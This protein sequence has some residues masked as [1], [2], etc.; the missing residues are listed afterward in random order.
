MP[1]GGFQFGGGVDRRS[2]PRMV[3]PAKAVEA[4]NCDF[5]SGALRPV[6][7]PTNGPEQLIP[8]GLIP[9]SLRR[10]PDSATWEVSGKRRTYSTVY[11]DPCWSTDDLSEPV[12]LRTASRKREAGV[13]PTTEDELRTLRPVINKSDILIYPTTEAPLLNPDYTWNN[14]EPQYL[15]NFIQVLNARWN[16]T[17]WEGSNLFVTV[18]RFRLG[19]YVTGG[20]RELAGKLAKGARLSLTVNGGITTYRVH[21]VEDI[22][23]YDAEDVVLAGGVGGAPI[24]GSRFTA[25]L[26]ADLVST[27]GDVVV[28]DGTNAIPSGVTEGRIYYDSGS[29]FDIGL[30][31]VVDRPKVFYGQVRV[32][33]EAG[34]FL[35]VQKVNE[36]LWDTSIVLDG[37]GVMILTDAYNDG[38]LYSLFGSSVTISSRQTLARVPIGAGTYRYQLTFVDEDGVESA[39]TVPGETYALVQDFRPPGANVQTVTIRPAARRVSDVTMVQLPQGSSQ[40][41]GVQG[42]PGHPNIQTGQLQTNRVAPPDPYQEVIVDGLSVEDYAGPFA[43]LM[44]ITGLGNLAVRPGTEF[45]NI[46]RTVAD[47][48]DFYLARTIKVVDGVP[49]SFIDAVHDYVLTGNPLCAVRNLFPPVYVEEGDGFVKRNGR[50]LTEYAG[51]YYLAS[52]NRLYFSE[53]SLHYWDVANY[54]QFDTDV[55]AVRVFGQTLVVTTRDGIYSVFGTGPQ[56]YVVGKKSTVGCADSNLVALAGGVLM[57][58]ANNDIY[59]YD[60]GAAVSATNEIVQPGVYNFAGARYC[61]V[62]EN[63][64]YVVIPDGKGVESIVFRYDLLERK[65]MPDLTWQG[66]PLAIFVDEGRGFVHGVVSMTSNHSGFGVVA[67]FITTLLPGNGADATYTYR[68]G[69][70]DDGAKLLKRYNL[71]Y[72]FFTDGDLDIQV[73]VDGRLRTTIRAQRDRHYLPDGLVGFDIQLLLQGDATVD[74]I[75]Y[76]FTVVSNE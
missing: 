69:R 51:R 39:P 34:E 68:T 20:T 42:P 52:G 72:P 26:L 73:L 45:I 57:F 67:T 47:G 76:D 22:N 46:Y 58:V 49:D 40:V 43:W 24:L 44:E 7:A 32:A 16:Q 31:G 30:Y 56:D 70:V 21:Q 36:D 14:G 71:I 19:I 62:F 61:F 13:A 48:V 55:T 6:A 1:R 18:Q 9:A 75:D 66:D 60:G 10:T 2:D 17:I 27:E 29:S 74:R 12:M 23:I 37:S 65:L 41:A 25:T 3:G 33:D 4:V 54:L 63:V 59:F 50:L 38:N 28:P 11:A 8:P 64:L 53:F 35:V 15:D 5:D